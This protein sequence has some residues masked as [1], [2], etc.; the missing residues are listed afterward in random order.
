M[1]SFL[2]GFE[3]NVQKY[4]QQKGFVVRDETLRNFF[5][6]YNCDFK[7][8]LKDKPGNY[9]FLFCVLAD[10]QDQND[11]TVIPYAIPPISNPEKKWNVHDLVMEIYKDIFNNGRKVT[12]DW[13][14][15]AIDTV[16]KLKPE[17]NN[18][19]WNNNA[20][21]EKAPQLHWKLL[22]EEK[23]Y[24]QNLCGKQ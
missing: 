20:K 21:Q 19:C 23:Y 3:K 11:S 9:G 1:R 16:E 14:Y 18:L 6:L 13:L 8:Y 12:G 22:K 15:S 5:T 2:T 7:V 10:V 17:K 4:Y 24:L